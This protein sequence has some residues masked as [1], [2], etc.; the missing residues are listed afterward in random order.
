MH[1]H[2][3]RPHTT[4]G[5]IVHAEEDNIPCL[6]M[7]TQHIRTADVPTPPQRC[8]KLLS[9][10][11][12]MVSTKEDAE[13]VLQPLTIEELVFEQAQDIFYSELPQTELSGGD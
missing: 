1:Y 4:G 12:A 7:E 8:E 13:E 3:Y 9:E 10:L 6:T 11:D 5:A 2:A